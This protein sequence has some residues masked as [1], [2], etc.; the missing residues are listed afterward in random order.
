VA[1]VLPA[2]VASARTKPKENYHVKMS[3]ELGSL[4]IPSAPPKQPPLILK[5]KPLELLEVLHLIIVD[6]L[7]LINVTVYSLDVVIVMG[8]LLV[9]FAS[10]KR[11]LNR[12][13]VLVK[14]IMG[15]GR[16]LIMDV[17]R[18]CLLVVELRAGIFVIVLISLDVRFV[19]VLLLDLFV[20]RKESLVN[21]IVLI[22]VGLG[23]LS[24]LDVVVLLHLR[25]IRFLRVSFRRSVIVRRAFNVGG[26]L[27]LLLLKER[28]SRGH[29][30]RLL[31]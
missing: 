23:W 30:V 9:L 4:I 24:L 18:L 29:I 8:H 25:L 10:L 21:S 17:V 12:V 11:D 16:H 1:I 15:L 13:K 26:V 5:L 31:K 7:V 22:I 2:Q 19:I 6:L 20:S 14:Q 28:I 27:V 3:P